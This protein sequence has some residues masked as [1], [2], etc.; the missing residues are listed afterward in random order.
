[1]THEELMSLARVCCAVLVVSGTVGLVVFVVV[2]TLAAGGWVAEAF[3]TDTT[4]RPKTT[5][6]PLFDGEPNRM[7]P[8]TPG[9]LTIGPV[10]PGPLPR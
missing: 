8:G 7:T 1:M 2:A 5:T 9:T 6:I 3:R 4:V 10:D